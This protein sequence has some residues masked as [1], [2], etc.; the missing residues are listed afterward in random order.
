MKLVRL[1]IL[2]SLMCIGLAPAA[3]SLEVVGDDQGD[4]YVGSG[5]VILPPSTNSS[6][7]DNAARC[8]L[9]RWRL[10]DPC[11]MRDPEQPQVC[12]FTP[13]PCP[14][15]T[16]LLLF[17]MSTDG[18]ATWNDRSLM[19]VAP[20]GPR[21]V[22]QLGSELRQEVIRE[23]PPL[24]PSHQPTRGIIPRIPVLWNSGQSPVTELVMPIHGHRVTITPR[25]TWTWTFPT[26]DP[27]RTQRPGSRYPN[28]E[29]SNIFRRAGSYRVHCQT[30]WTGEF[31]VDDLGPFAIS[32]PIVQDAHLRVTVADA[33]SVLGGTP[34]KRR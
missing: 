12:S 31:F 1:L 21:T 20:G 13:M 10:S 25:P 24:A 22:A 18:G 23:L 6:I 4:R 28:D 15:G 26:G 11:P 5:G 19:C 3:L 9:C 30:E 34:A 16:E 2:T 17:S 32:E 8:Q 33:R 7:R 29:V 27:L 14:E